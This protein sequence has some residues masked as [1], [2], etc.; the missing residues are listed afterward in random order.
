MKRENVVTKGKVIIA[1][2]I[3]VI[4]VAAWLL[5]SSGPQMGGPGGGMGQMPPP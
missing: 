3:G 5:A 2:V 1:L 4:G